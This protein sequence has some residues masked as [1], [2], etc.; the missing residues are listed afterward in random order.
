MNMTDDRLQQ[1]ENGFQ[2]LQLLAE[3]PENIDG[4]TLLY[5]I[6]LIT[7]KKNLLEANMVEDI[8]FWRAKGEQLKKVL[9][10]Q[11]GYLRRL[12][13]QASID[14]NIDTDFDKWGNA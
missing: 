9:I 5:E 8:R 1:F 14:E 6:L 7:V 11:M 13:A 2:Q 3:T 10:R 4:F 12:K